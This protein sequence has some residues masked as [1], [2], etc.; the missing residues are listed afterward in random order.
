M[1]EDD[2]RQDDGSMHAKFFANYTL[3]FECIAHGDKDG[4]RSYLERCVENSSSTQV[5]SVSKIREG[6]RADFA[7]TG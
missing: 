7:R 6:F 2:Y 1:S 4:A 5:V 3:A